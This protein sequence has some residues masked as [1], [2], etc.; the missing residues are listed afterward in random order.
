MNI[1]YAS[2]QL[3]S[4]GCR[5][6]RF[7]KERGFTLRELAQ[8]LEISAP[9]VSRWEN[10]CTNPRQ[11]K[12]S[13]LANALGVSENEL[14]P[15]IG[16]RFEAKPNSTAQRASDFPNPIEQGRNLEG[17][18]LSDLIRT[19]KAQIAAAAGTSPDRITI[20]IEV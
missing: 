2:L 15:E 16:E 4:L 17:A 9:A 5:I 6:R 10:G 14:L 7:R 18:R 20:K 12:L 3:E 1:A 8:A 11:K 19:A 13:R